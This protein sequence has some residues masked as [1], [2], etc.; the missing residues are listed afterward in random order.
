M[1]IKKLYLKAHNELKKLYGQETPTL[2]YRIFEHILQKN[3]VEIFLNFDKKINSRILNKFNK[4]LILLKNYY[5][6][7]YIFNSAQCFG[8]EFYV[9]ESVFIPRPETE[10]LIEIVLSY[11]NITNNTTIIDI[12]TGSGCIALNIKKI[13]NAEVFAADISE[14]ALTTAKYNADK[15]NLHIKFIK[16]DIANPP[17]LT[18]K[19]DIIISN[20][21]YVLPGEQTSPN[22]YY[23]P[24]QAIFTP[25]NDPLF[26]Y[27]KILDFAQNYLKKYGKIFLELNE[28]TADQIAQLYQKNGFKTLIIK[29][30]NNKKRFL[31]SEYV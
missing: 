8:S 1:T 2:I 22:I 17:D 4:A 6:I 24:Q 21:P 5:P 13:T 20:P 9:D 27:K 10:Q 30:L 7:Q 23:E 31:I 29:D 28:F 25:K 3:A 14:D 11:T 26:F 19:F 16:M 15:L 18:T 12:G